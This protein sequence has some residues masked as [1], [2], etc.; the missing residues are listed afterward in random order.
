[1]ATIPE[2]NRA[3]ADQ[4]CDETKRGVRNYTPGQL[5]GIANGQIVVVATDLAEVVR[6]LETVESDAA[7]TFIVEP[8]RD[9]DEVHQ[10]WEMINGARP[11]AAR[12]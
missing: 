7:M 3:L 5:V 9:Y 2:L 6:R 4:L 11:M 8:A 10:V 1:M 12:R